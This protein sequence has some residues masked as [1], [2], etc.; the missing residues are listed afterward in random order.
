MCEDVA[1]V[2]PELQAGHYLDGYRIEILE[3][4]V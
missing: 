3:M 2:V 4:E 1:L